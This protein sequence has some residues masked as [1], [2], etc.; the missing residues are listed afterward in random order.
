MRKDI[1]DTICGTCKRSA[2]K[3]S[4]SAKYVPVEGWEAI[5]T[6]IAVDKNFDDSYAVLSCPKYVENTRYKPKYKYIFR[7]G[8]EEKICVGREETEAFI[9]TYESEVRRAVRHGRKIKGYDVEK[10]LV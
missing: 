7:K 10:C 6:K 9:G 8:S 1:P 3:C 2:G 4:W 5:P